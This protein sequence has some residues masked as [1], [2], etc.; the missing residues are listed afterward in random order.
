MYAWCRVQHGSAAP[1]EAFALAEWFCQYESA[2]DEYRGLCAISSDTAHCDVLS[3]PR[4][5]EHAALFK[6][7]SEKYGATAAALADDVVEMTVDRPASTQEQALE[8]A[9]HQ[10]IYCPDIV[11]QGVGSVAALAATLLGATVWYFGC[12]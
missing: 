6:Y 2:T 9:R 1:Q 3:L 4:A 5:E 7:W 8:L 12:D 10:F 11:Y